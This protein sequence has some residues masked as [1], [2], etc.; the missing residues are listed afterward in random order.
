MLAHAALALSLAVRVYDAYGVSAVTL[1]R[2]QRAVDRILNDADLRVRWETCPCAETVGSAELVVRISA[3]P[4]VSDQSALG[5]SYIDVARK[6]GTLA[7]VFG[8]R[9][10][11]MARLAGADEGE[12]LGRAMAH[13]VAHLL[14]GT[15]DHAP[16]G[17]M[18]GRWDVGDLQR[19]QPWEWT[20]SRTDAKT[21]RDALTRRRR[22]DN[23]E[24]LRVE[25]R[26]PLE[27]P[28]GDA[29]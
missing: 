25:L 29:E 22:D 9:V 27:I 2:A 10:H 1:A 26:E 5:Y 6:A 15:H 7:T 14:L 12:L 18:R 17:L 8:D 19:N 3:A 28:L 23:G 13:E 11:A 21:M 16:A 4:A 20:L 24:G